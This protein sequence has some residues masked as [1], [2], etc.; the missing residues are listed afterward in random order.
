[1]TVA[2]QWWSTN[3]PIVKFKNSNGENQV[4]KNDCREIQLD[5]IIFQNFTQVRG[6]DRSS[7]NRR[8]ST[9][10]RSMDDAILHIQLWR[11]TLYFYETSPFT[12]ALF[13]P[14]IAAVVVFLLEALHRVVVLGHFLKNLQPP[15]CKKNL[16]LLHVL[17]HFLILH[18]LAWQLLV[19]WVDFGVK[20]K[21]WCKW[22][23]LSGSWPNFLACFPL[24]LF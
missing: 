19:F 12:T 10:A 2:T 17:Q 21:I 4:T 6:E 13:R 24:L 9:E 16:M 20:L 3:S 8:F 14:K 23:L 11:V 7:G 1:M 15:L 18:F 22:V 5:T